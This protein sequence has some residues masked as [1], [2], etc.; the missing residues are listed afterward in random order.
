MKK[1]GWIVCLYGI[2]IANVFWASGFSFEYF[3]NGQAF[4]WIFYLIMPLAMNL[5]LI[6]LSYYITR[7]RLRKIPDSYDDDNPKWEKAGLKLF[8][9]KRCLLFILI[10]L[11]LALFIMFLI[12]GFK[13]GGFNYS[14]AF[15]PIG[16]FSYTFPVNSYTSWVWHHQL[17]A[18]REVSQA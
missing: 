11:P 13:L 14:A 7:K 8:I 16:F 3:F 5:F 12:S 10:M 15:I 4:D 18:E 1:E 6:G 2:F 9:I 17:K